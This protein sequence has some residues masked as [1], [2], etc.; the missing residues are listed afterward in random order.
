MATTEPEVDAEPHGDRCEDQH[1]DC[2][3]RVCRGTPLLLVDGG[4]HHRSDAA[5]ERLGCADQALRA[6]L[7]FLGYRHR[8]GHTRGRDGETVG[9][10]VPHRE[11]E[12]PLAR[13]QL[14]VRRHEER[15][16]DQPEPA[17]LERADPL[18]EA[19]A[20]RTE[21]DERNR[22]E[23]DAEIRHPVGGAEVFVHDVPQR[24]ERADHQEHTAAHH[25]GT[26]DNPGTQKVEGESL[27]AGVDGLLDVERLCDGE[28]R[29]G[30]CGDD[31]VRCSKPERTYEHGRQG[32]T[33]GKAEDVGA[34]Q[35]PQVLAE[36][37]RVG[38]DHDATDRRNRR[39]DAE[40]GDDPAGQQHPEAL[41]EPEHEDAD[42]VEQ[43]AGPNQV[44]GMASVADRCDQGLGE[45][46]HDEP[47]ADQPT[48]GGL[49]D[50][51]GVAVVGD[52]RE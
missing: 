5:G 49:A 41:T 23:C 30:G 25:D 34:E 42:D 13:G 27:T 6:R 21:D 38:Q 8:N 24:I 10:C 51:V 9:E 32:R 47:E 3:G 45:E 19:T 33:H 17:N 22:E 1:A 16:G 36:V 39:T 48:D 11:H 52:D 15:T 2:T 31:D 50:A 44:A 35:S 28:H 46:G 40:A 29:Q 7:T 14:A 12:D 26:G 20:E 43:H 4:D 37:L 18:A